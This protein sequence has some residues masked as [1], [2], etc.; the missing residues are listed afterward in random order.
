MSTTGGRWRRIAVSLMA[1]GASLSVSAPAGVAAVSSA[2]AHPA[3]QQ[4]LVFLHNP[5]RLDTGLQASVSGLLKSLGSRNVEPFHIINAVAA[6]VS[7]DT[8]DQLR[9]NPDVAAVQPDRFRTY[10]LDNGPSLSEEVAATAAQRLPATAGAGAA[11]A[12]A[13][14]PTSGPQA[15]AP[16]WNILNATPGSPLFSQLCTHEANDVTHATEANAAG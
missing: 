1:A 5:M 13:I 9:Q 11:A 16:C 15:T 12:A 8:V 6:T 3:D 14:P 7:Q 4:V 10:S 2:A